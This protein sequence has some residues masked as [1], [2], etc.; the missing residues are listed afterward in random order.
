MAQRF[1]VRR[2]QLIGEEETLARNVPTAN[3]AVAFSASRTGVLAFKSSVSADVTKLAWFDRKGT[4][5]ATIGDTGLY[6]NVNVTADGRTIVTDRFDSVT[7]ERHVW[8]IDASRGSF[9]RPISD[10]P[11]DYAA[12]ISADGRIAF[13]SG[14][15]LFLATASGA[16]RPEPLLSSSTAKHANDWSPDGR[17]LLY[18]DHHPTQQQDLWLIP[19]TGDRK[20][21]PFLTTM[22]DESPGQFSPDGRLIAYG[23]NETGRR[24][25]YVRDFSAGPYSGGR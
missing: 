16:A 23:S 11:E 8:A 6:G 12:D 24:E 22:A 10:Q 14:N 1:D 13:T 5:L 17:F 9:T 18:D 2:L 4:P 19:M 21:I 20:P 15:D 25:I 7:G 3:P